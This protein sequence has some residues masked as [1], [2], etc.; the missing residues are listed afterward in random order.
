LSEGE[1]PTLPTTGESN[2]LFEKFGLWTRHSLEMESKKWPSDLSDS[3]NC[4]ITNGK[5]EKGEIQ[6]DSV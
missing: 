2:R 5:Q 3:E 4:L 1:R 6:P